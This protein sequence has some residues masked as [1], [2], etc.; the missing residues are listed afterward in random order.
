MRSRA[1][2][3]AHGA[4]DRSAAKSVDRALAVT[5]RSRPRSSH[6]A[7]PTSVVW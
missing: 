3:V 1:A 6:P 2:T 4:R 5:A 7:L